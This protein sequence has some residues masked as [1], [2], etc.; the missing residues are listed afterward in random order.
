MSLHMFWPI[1]VVVAANTIYNIVAKLT[2]GSVNAF[3]SLAVTYAIAALSSVGLFFFTASNKHFLDEV[4]KT[5][6]TAVVFGLAIVGL[7]FG[8]LWIYRAGWKLSTASLVANI[9]LAIVLLA[10][11]TLAWRETFS[12]VQG[13][14]VVL[15][16]IGLYCIAR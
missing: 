13:L 11:G 1:A 5:D 3:A 12:A 7:E 15:C 16:C 4:A 9:S 10:I 8:Y 14:G 6:W 2:P